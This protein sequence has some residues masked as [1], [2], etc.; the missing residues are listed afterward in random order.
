ASVSRPA[1]PTGWAVN[2]PPLETE[3]KRLARVSVPAASRRGFL[4][5]RLQHA[6]LAFGR[7]RLGGRRLQLAAL[8]LGRDSLL[9]RLF[10]MALR[11][12]SELV[13]V[14]LRKI[15]IIMPCRLLDILEGKCAIGIG[16]AD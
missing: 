14:G 1:R 9:G 15:D 3:G 5:F 12:D 8:A 7:H 10:A 6:A 4:R 11:M 2:H 16:H 13:P